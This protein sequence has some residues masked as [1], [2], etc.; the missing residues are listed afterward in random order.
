ME[1]IASSLKG[2]RCQDRVPGS[3]AIPGAKS[4]IFW[5][6]VGLEKVVM[7]VWEQYR[8]E[9]RHL[10]PLLTTARVR[11]RTENEIYA[12]TFPQVKKKRKTGKA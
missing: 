7:D 8:H 2:N 9:K 10:R 5:G 3:T 6:L 1:I 4:K 11:S 12:R